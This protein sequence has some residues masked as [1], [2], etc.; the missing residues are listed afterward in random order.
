MMYAQH[1]STG[2]HEK[3]VHEDAL[4]F[5]Q[6]TQMARAA[7]DLLGQKLGRSE[8]QANSLGELLMRADLLSAGDADLHQAI[9]EAVET[10]TVIL[11]DSEITGIIELA[12]TQTAPP[13]AFNNTHQQP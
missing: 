2:F 9:K 3:F 1:Q 8:Q 6:A 7:G 11:T 5:Q 4:Q 12:R 13:S 10:T